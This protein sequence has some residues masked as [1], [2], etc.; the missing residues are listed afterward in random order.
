M[1]KLL[2]FVLVLGIGGTVFYLK[3]DKVSSEVTL[4]EDSSWVYPI[5]A[6]TTLRTPGLAAAIS[7]AGDP[8]LDY[9][10]YANSQ[11]GFSYYHSP[12]ANMKEYDE[13]GGAMTIVQENE[14]NM[15][16]LQIFIVPYDKEIITEERFA[17]D[18]PSGVKYNIRNATLGEKKVPAVT[19]N[20][21][22][23]FLGE[24]REVWFIYDG[25]L[26]EITTFKGFGDWFAPIMQTWRFLD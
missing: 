17:K 1:K 3:D 21:E 24:T 9:V 2:I 22:D 20:S 11:Y 14:E 10:Q 5:T 26:Y 18:I 6:T 7:D 16:G 13:G 15:R 19:F 4:F 12:Q 25:Y 8:P 23:T